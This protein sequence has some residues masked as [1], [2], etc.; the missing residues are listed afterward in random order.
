[1]IPLSAK[2]AL[3]VGRDGSGAAAAGLLRRRGVAVSEV[4][5]GTQGPADVVLVVV[6][7]GAG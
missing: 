1:M 5:S 6:S 7:G 3:V 4:T 2:R